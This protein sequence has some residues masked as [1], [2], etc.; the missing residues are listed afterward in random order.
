[1]MIRLE[2]LNFQIE[3]SKS[4]EFLGHR[5]SNEHVQT[6]YLPHVSFS[7]G[8]FSKLKKMPKK[9]ADSNDSVGLEFAALEMIASRC[10]VVQVTCV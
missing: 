6:V 7:N 3:F 2:F 10:I 5:L 8:K 9:S 4:K 1:M